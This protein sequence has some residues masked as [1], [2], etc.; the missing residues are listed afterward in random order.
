MRFS[1]R[2]K[3][4]VLFIL[5]IL[6]PVASSSVSL[7]LLYAFN[8]DAKEYAKS[9]IL[10]KET[11]DLVNAKYGLAEDYDAFY[12]A[13]EPSLKKISGHLQIIDSKGFVIFDSMDKQAS[14]KKNQ[15][16]ISAMCSYDP[17]YSLK[18]PTM[19][20]HIN[21]I[22]VNRTQVASAIIIKDMGAFGNGIGKKLTIYSSICFFIGLILLAFVFNRFV[23]KTILNP[24]KTLNMATANIMEGN[25]DFRVDYNGKD[26]LGQV[27]NAFETMR[28]KL[29]ESLEQQAFYDNARKELLASISHDLRTPITSIKGYVEGL[30]D[31]IPKDENKFK[32]YLSI[33]KN[34]TANLDRLI[35]D[36]FKFTQEDA[37]ILDIDLVETDSCSM[38]EG[39]ICSIEA[40]LE[41]TEVKISVQRPFPSRTILADPFR[42]TQVMENIIQ[43][44]RKYAG[45]AC[46][47]EIKVQEMDESILVSVKDNGPGIS[48]ED[49]PKV[50]ER[51]YRGEKSRSRKFGGIGIGLTICRQIVEAHGG[52]IWAESIIGKGATFFF[53][54]PELKDK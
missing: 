30:Q 5:I 10:L 22:V 8:N 21:P 34:K 9:G 28:I 38:F 16:D 45:A 24:L 52:R 51:F 14:L 50:F 42:I 35:D 33:I 19:H 26:E 29:K 54:L 3:L 44:A 37:G 17:K 46:E 32:K 36:L 15:V 27:C 18:Y 7:S 39:I 25:L 41:S 48:E 53:T 49:L 23:K 11:F 31:G 12:A 4:A 43:N 13:L 6:I 20:K 47:I 40:D 1:I 2:T